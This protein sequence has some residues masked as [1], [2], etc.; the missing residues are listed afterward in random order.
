MI[1]QRAADRCNEGRSYLG[2]I[3][4]QAHLGHSIW[5]NA[6]Y[7]LLDRAPANAIKFKSKLGAEKLT[8]FA[9]VTKCCDRL[10]YC[11]GIFIRSTL[12]H[13]SR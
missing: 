4:Q 8:Y 2:S 10:L 6:W 11:Y 12:S 1:L 3:L 5:V 13:L 7:G 9:R